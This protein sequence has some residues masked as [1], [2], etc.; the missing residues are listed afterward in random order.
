MHVLGNW[1][2]R[3]VVGVGALL[4]AGAIATVVRAGIPGGDGLIHGCYSGN[5]AT[6]TNGTQ[7]NVVDSGSSCA[8]GQTEISWNQTGPQGPAGA[9]GAAGPAGPAGSTGPAGAQGPA[10]PQGPA[11]VSGYQQAS[12]SGYVGPLSYLYLDVWCP[13]GKMPLG[14][15]ASTE[16][17]NNSLQIVDSRPLATGWEIR[18]WNG[19]IFTG[20][21]GIAYVVC[22]NVT[23]T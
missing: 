15:G 9:A 4:A 23:V 19:D 14:G 22:G 16:P 3:V 20:H 12:R 2:L 17:G 8:K 6:A 13:S 7:L 21:T 1:R 18:F 10:G 11:G 5:G